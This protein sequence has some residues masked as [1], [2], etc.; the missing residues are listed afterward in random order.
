MKDTDSL[1]LSKNILYILLKKMVFKL[2]RTGVIIGSS[3]F[4]FANF[5]IYSYLPSF[6]I[7]S[8]EPRIS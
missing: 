7:C 6:I 1:F 5:F 4:I 8:F 3:N 2:E